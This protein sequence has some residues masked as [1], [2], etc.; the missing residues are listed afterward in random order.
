VGVQI[1]KEKNFS[2]WNNPFTP[3]A[4][5]KPTTGSVSNTPIDG[6]SLFVH[7]I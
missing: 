2:D 6:D 4:N 7:Y 5:T 3:N 1:S